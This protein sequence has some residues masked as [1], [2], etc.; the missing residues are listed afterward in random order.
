MRLEASWITLEEWTLLRKPDREVKKG[1]P[2]VMFFDGSK[3][4]DH[5][6][7]GG[8]LHGGWAHLQD[9]ALET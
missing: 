5:T 2:I 3:S 7:L 8:L 4:N 1:E 9:R 6:A